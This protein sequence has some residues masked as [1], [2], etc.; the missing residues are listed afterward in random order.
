MG[1]RGGRGGRKPTGVGD[2]VHVADWFSFTLPNYAIQPS[3][4]RIIGESASGKA[5]LVDVETETQDGERDLVY[6][7]YMPK[8]AAVTDAQLKAAEK[9]RE[10]NYKDGQKRYAAM[11][12]FAKK[13]NIKGVR[14]G[15][16]KETILEKIR[17][18]GSDYKY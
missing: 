6:Q 17:K 18:A 13:N 11:V 9:I 1:G 8:A 12:E 4:V 5:W 15:L 10:K 3:V 2:R 7:K 16:R 14:V